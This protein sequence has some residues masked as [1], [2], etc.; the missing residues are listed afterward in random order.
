MDSAHP[1]R[2]TL[3]PPYF[4]LSNQHSPKGWEARSSFR[5]TE[6]RTSWCPI[7]TPDLK[8]G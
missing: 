6:G 7:S 3:P 2:S 8:G 4:S 1:Y 5:V